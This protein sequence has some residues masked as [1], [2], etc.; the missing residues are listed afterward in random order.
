M[1]DEVEAVLERCRFSKA[2]E[3]NQYTCHIFY[4]THLTHMLTDDKERKW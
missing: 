1:G 3:I 4:K 2:D